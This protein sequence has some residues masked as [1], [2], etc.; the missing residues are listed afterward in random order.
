MFLQRAFQFSLPKLRFFSEMKRK[1]H[2]SWNKLRRW[3]RDIIQCQ[4]WLVHLKWSEHWLAKFLVKQVFSLSGILK[5]TRFES[6]KSQFL[7]FQIWFKINV[8]PLNNSAIFGHNLNYTKILFITFILFTKVASV[9]LHKLKV[10][11]LEWL[12]L[13]Y[14]LTAGEGYCIPRDSYRRRVRAWITWFCLF[15]L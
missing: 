9:F 8:D 11:Q 12:W 2:I 1:T 15:F 3:A 7:T 13:S 6:C 10:S 14:W 5:T 4:L